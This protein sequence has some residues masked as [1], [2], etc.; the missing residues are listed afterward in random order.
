MR[1]DEGGGW[2]RVCFPTIRVSGC[3]YNIKV[4]PILVPLVGEKVNKGKER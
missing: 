3:R 2:G 4:T 1:F